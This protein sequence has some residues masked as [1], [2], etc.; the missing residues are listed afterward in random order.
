MAKE[1]FCILC[2]R[3][4]EFGS[5]ATDARILHNQAQAKDARDN[6][7]TQRQYPG[8]TGPRTDCPGDFRFREIKPKLNRPIAK[9][10]VLGG[11]EPW[12]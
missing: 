5:T 1:W 3:F 10:G 2:H 11:D 7:W 6:E 9:T 12:I 4:G 8:F